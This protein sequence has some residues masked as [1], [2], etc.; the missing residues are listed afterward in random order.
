MS[1][2]FY[3]LMSTD[4]SISLALSRHEFDSLIKSYQN[5]LKVGFHI[6]GM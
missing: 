3:G 1:L 2:H 4:Y 5:T 6:V